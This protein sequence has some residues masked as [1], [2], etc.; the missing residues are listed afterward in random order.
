M[1]VAFCRETWVYSIL[2]LMG[3]NIITFSNCVFFY[4][5]WCLCWSSAC[6]YK[7]I[8]LPLPGSM[9][10]DNRKPPPNVWFDQYSVPC[11]LCHKI[12]ESLRDENHS[13]ELTE[14][15]WIVVP[16]VLL[17]Y[18]IQTCLK[19]DA[20]IITNFTSRVGWHFSSW[21]LVSKL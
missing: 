20:P 12:Y 3:S 8:N 13:T 7:I 2:K 15:I 1:C 4:V 19:T 18:H 17:Y 9:S 6:R 14:S 10:G 21:T 5:S 16:W 11:L